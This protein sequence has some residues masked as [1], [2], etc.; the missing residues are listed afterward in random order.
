[1]KV[2]KTLKK[3]N[4]E[5][6]LGRVLPRLD[7]AS[8]VPVKLFFLILYILGAVLI[9]NTQV[10]IAASTKK[11]AYISPIAEFAAKNIFVTYL[12][13]AGIAVTILILFPIGKRSVQDQLKSIG[14]VNHADA[15]PELKSK[16]KDKQNPKISIWEFTSQGIPLKVWKD[17]QAAI[18]TSLDITVVK[19]KNGSGKSRVLI[20]AVPAVSDLPDMIQWK[21]KYLSQQS[22]IL[23]LGE[24][25]T[26]PVTVDLARVPHILLGGATGSGKSVLLKLLLMQ[27]N[28]KGATV[29]IADFKGGVDFP[30]IWHKE[31]RMCFEEQSTLELLTELVD[32]L[33]HRKQ[34][35]SASGLPNIDHHNAATGDNLKRYIFACDELAEMLDKTGLTKDQKE[36][37]IKIEGKLSIIARQ[38]R[39]F[40]IHLILATQ[41]PDSTILNG[42]IKNNINC[43]ICGR[44]DNVLSMIIL[45]NTDAADLIPE[46]AQG[47]FLLNDGTMFRAYWFDDA[48]GIAGPHP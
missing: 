13:I 25:F 20:Y 32:E 28:K 2:T 40:G 11:I 36:I 15:V 38:G 44:A 23:N 10:D 9:W 24:S 6:S 19:M 12:I 29:C 7:S 22:F 18:E 8:D 39:A 48:A 31:C 47:R 34:L 33:E 27:A 4:T 35:L 41:R 21:D 17:K 26:G 14:L 3:T 43:R 1:M 16:R 30:P 37:I 42:Q 5:I 46:D 45:D